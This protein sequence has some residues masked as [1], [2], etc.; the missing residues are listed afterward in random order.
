MKISTKYMLGVIV[1]I[2]VVLSVHLSIESL[3]WHGKIY[4]AIFSA[5]LVGSTIGYFISTSLSKNFAELKKTAKN[6]SN[7]DFSKNANIDTTGHF[8]D[9]TADIA[10][11]INLMLDSLRSLANH[12]TETS[13]QV[14]QSSI[15]LYK[16]SDQVNESTNEIKSSFDYVNKGAGKQL[17]MIE[18]MYKTINEMAES[19][20]VI[21][22]NAREVEEFEKQST[23]NAKKG[24]ETAKET[25]KKLENVFEKV[26]SSA[27]QVLKFSNITER[28]STIVDVLTSIA[29]QT[30][31]LALNASIEA[32]KAGDAGKGFST[33]VADIKIMSEDSKNAATQITGLLK[34]IELESDKTLKSMK[35]SGAEI[36]EGRKMLST[37]N[38]TLETIVSLV[39]ESEMKMSKITT[40]TDL[41]LVKTKEIVD[42]VNEVATLSQENKNATENIAEASEDQMLSIA[43]M[44][45]SALKMHN[46][47]EK[48]KETTSKFKLKED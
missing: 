9:E 36:A 15:N 17:L 18:E 31:I 12:I 6:I 24:G 19:S 26:E 13:T 28:I 41:H 1:V 45:N 40:L 8:V 30:N 23:S 38:S 47:S 44:S 4:L 2:L 33:V 20:E 34:E 46:L 25:L 21:A 39:T 48:L 42:Y 11:S 32:S 3:H 16:L 27:E 43:E 5:L 14:L 22:E 10:T 7:G 29:K 37:T 35:E